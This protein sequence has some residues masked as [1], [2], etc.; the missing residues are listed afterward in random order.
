MIASR[1]VFRSASFF[2]PVSSSLRAFAA[3]AEAGPGGPAPE[4]YAVMPPVDFAQAGCWA[5]P[6]AGGHSVLAALPDD[7]AESHSVSAGC[8]AAPQAYGHSAL[9]APPDGSAELDSESACCWVAPQV[10]DHSVLVAPPDD[11]AESHSEPAGC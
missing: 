10:D 3:A 7:W 6:Q 5:A 4:A 8:W 11:W 2:R 9:V 1:S